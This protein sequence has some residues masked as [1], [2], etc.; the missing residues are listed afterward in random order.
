LRLVAI[1]AALVALLVLPVLGAEQPS[2]PPFPRPNPSAIEEQLESLSEELEAPEPLDI[3]PIDEA[4]LAECERELQRFGAEFERLPDIADETDKGCGVGA[5]Y[6]LSRAAPDVVLEPASQL[7]CETALALVRWVNDTVLPAANALGNDVRLVRIVHGSTYICRRRNNQTDGK[8]SEHALGRAI[9][10][11]SFGFEGHEPIPV[12]ARAGDGNLAE[13]FQRA[14]RGGACLYFTTVLG[15]GSDAFH[16][17]H[18]HLDILPRNRAYR[19]C[20]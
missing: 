7:T 9:D 10:I 14:A 19:L 16:T 2:P 8:I 18:L 11:L 15:P 4:A 3:G 6:N 12:V 1:C 17:D 5:P 20:Q 13:S